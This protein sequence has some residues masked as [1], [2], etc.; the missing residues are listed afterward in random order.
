MENFLHSQTP[1]LVVRENF[2]PPQDNMTSFLK[3]QKPILLKKGGRTEYYSQNG[4]T[5]SIKNLNQDV[6]LI[7]PLNTD[8]RFS[9]ELPLYTPNGNEQAGQ[10]KTHPNL[11]IKE[12]FQMGT[13]SSLP[14]Q[15]V[16]PPLNTDIRFSD[17]LPCEACQKNNDVDHQHLVPYSNI[18]SINDLRENFSW[19]ITTDQDNEQDKLK[20]KLIHKVNT[21][22]ACGSCWAVCM[23]DV[24]SDCLVVSGAVNWYPDISSTYLMACVPQSEGHTKCS[25]GNPAA[26]AK[27]LEETKTILAD[28]TCL[29]YSWCDGDSQVCTSIGSVQH[30]SAQNLAQTLNNNIPNCGCYFSGPKFVYTLDRG[31]DSLYI[32]SQLTVDKFRNTVKTHI[33]DFGPLVGGFAVLRN[34]FSG[35][36]TKFNGGVYLDRADY[37]HYQGSGPLSFDDGQTQDVAGFHAVAV[38]GWGVAKNIQYDTNQWGDVPYW[39]CR[40]SWS[41]QWGDEGYFKIAMYPFNQVSQFGTQV[42]TNIGGPVGSLMLIRATQP[43]KQM[44]L[45]TITPQYLQ[46]IQRIRKDVFYQQDPNDIQS[47]A[48][49]SLD[50][51]KPTTEES[52]SSSSTTIW[53]L[54]L[55]FILL[56]VIFFMNK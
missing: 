35:N 26:V 8:I 52:S 37:N 34:F 1:S 47:A 22:H 28:S 17:H 21:Q 49:A 31:S 43:P 33:V 16:I 19:A 40:N 4:S 56:L 23:A 32:T 20:K 48:I 7:P 14:D 12:D 3:S 36:F 51:N 24:I 27:Y 5:E 30:F 54:A 25:G 9:V 39:H 13:I 10:S 6:L 2:Q 44:T 45:K 55:F 53:I 50:V 18:N 46:T 29:D 15:L 42:M 11:I 38:L 41:T